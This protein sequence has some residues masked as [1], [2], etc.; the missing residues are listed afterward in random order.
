MLIRRANI[1]DV[2]NITVLKQ[3]VW[4]A[5][6]AEEG[7]RTEFSRYVLDAFTVENIKN[8]IKDSSRII[9]IAENKNHLIGCVEIALN[10]KC[11]VELQQD[12]PEIVVLYVLD[13]FKGR[14]IGK[15]LLEKAIEYIQR[16]NHSAVWLTV[17]HKNQMAL[18]FYL[19]NQFKI[20]GSTDFIMDGNRYENS[21]LL[22]KIN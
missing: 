14:G 20:I 2:L 9:L 12:C 10:E 22:R 8:T 16:L 15:L 11:P 7:I 6:Y 1:D 18:E 4:I 3:Q 17:Y 19:K 13:R 21:V 5:T